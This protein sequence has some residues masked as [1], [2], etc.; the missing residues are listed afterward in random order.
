MTL[1][2]ALVRVPSDTPVDRARD[3]LEGAHTNYLL[4]VDDH[5]LVGVVG[6]GELAGDIPGRNT[7]LYRVEHCPWVIKDTATLAEAAALMVE[8]DVRCLPVVRGCE[9]RGVIS[10]ADLRRVGVEIEELVA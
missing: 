4:V 5:Q 8:K 7:L 3:V 2:P 6:A 9:L 10:D 1:A